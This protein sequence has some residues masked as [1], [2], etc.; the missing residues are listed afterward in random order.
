MGM[1]GSYARIHKM[2]ENIISRNQGKLKESLA[3]VGEVDGQ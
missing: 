1:K 3:G 2:Y